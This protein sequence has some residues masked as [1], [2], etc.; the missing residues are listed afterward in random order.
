MDK[1]Q[2]LNDI[3]YENRV[4]IVTEGLQNQRTLKNRVTN[5]FK[6]GMRAYRKFGYAKH[7]CENPENVINILKNF[8]TRTLLTM[9][10][11]SKSTKFPNNLYYNILCVQKCDEFLQNPFIIYDN[12]SIEEFAEMCPTYQW[13]VRIKSNLNK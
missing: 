2:F 11:C 9:Y 1:F 6:Y 7:L 4:H 10:A 12:K 3:P 8:T 5:T 13:E